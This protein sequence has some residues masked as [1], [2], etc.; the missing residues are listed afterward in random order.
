MRCR[1]RVQPVGYQVSPGSKAAFGYRHQSDAGHPRR[2][3]AAPLSAQCRGRPVRENTGIRESRTQFG[4][5]I[6]DLLNGARAVRKP[7]MIFPRRWVVAVAASI[8]DVEQEQLPEE[9][10]SDHSGRRAQIYFDSW[11]EAGRP[12][13][14]KIITD[15]IDHPLCE[16]RSP[17]M[18]AE[19]IHAHPL[20]KKCEWMVATVRD[21]A[22]IWVPTGLMSRSWHYASVAVSAC[23]RARWFG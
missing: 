13:Q 20:R 14:L 16:L 1:P 17:L 8:G 23:V 3:S 5:V 11:A 15:L 2:D 12:F 22:I 6:K 4:G 10:G 18:T 7:A 19:P 9:P 21:F